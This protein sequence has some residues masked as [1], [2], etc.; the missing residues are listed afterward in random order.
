MFQA[1]FVKF[2]NR[3]PFIE[4]LKTLT[5]DEEAE[6]LTSIDK[7]LELK[8]NNNIISNKLS[9]YLRDGIFEL[10][11]SHLNK[12]SRSLYFF[13]K[14]KRIIFTHG[15][16]KKVQKTPSDEIDKALKMKK[17]YISERNKNAN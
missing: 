4:F 15:F 12:I 16:I 1:D 5:D 8:N 3:I 10:R 11:V 13:V 7:L 9:K 14:E 6:I 17:Y 2:N